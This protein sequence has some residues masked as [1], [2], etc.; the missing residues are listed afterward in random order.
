M[1]KW[2]AKLD[3]NEHRSRMVSRHHVV[4]SSPKQVYIRGRISKWAAGFMGEAFIKP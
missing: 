4:S 1:P 2:A 3:V